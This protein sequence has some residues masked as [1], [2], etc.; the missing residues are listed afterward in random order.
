MT[1]TQKLKNAK[2]YSGYELRTSNRES[3][4]VCEEAARKFSENE[5]EY[6]ALLEALFIY[7]LA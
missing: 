6:Q 5:R 2:A 3:Y 4:E 1:M 7:W